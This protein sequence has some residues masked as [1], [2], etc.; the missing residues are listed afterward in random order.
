MEDV[1]MAC[2][3]SYFA[4]TGLSALRAE[5]DNP[6]IETLLD[7]L[8]EQTQRLSGIVE[9]LLLLSRADARTLILRIEA[10]EFSTMC[11]DLAEDA[12]ALVVQP[13]LFAEATPLSRD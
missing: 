12:E 11:H 5:V 3:Q 1:F 13:T 4:D 6:R 9:K 2:S 10:V 8:L 7:G